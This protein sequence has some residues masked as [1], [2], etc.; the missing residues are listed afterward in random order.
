ME[1]IS[2]GVQ[3]R[4]RF[5]DPHISLQQ[6]ICHKPQ[7]KTAYA[8]SVVFLSKRLNSIISKDKRG[9][10]GAHYMGSYRQRYVHILDSCHIE[11]LFNMA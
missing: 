4:N 5:G 2:P 6:R 3:T 1:H 10:H 8:D 7:P 11:P 9:Y